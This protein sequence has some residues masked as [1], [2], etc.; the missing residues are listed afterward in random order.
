MQNELITNGFGG[1]LAPLLLD[2]LG[3]GSGGVDL[4]HLLA[5]DAGLNV[6]SP[7][8]DFPY[9]DYVRK[10]ILAVA[11]SS[12]DHME[13]GQTIL[14]LGRLTEV[15]NV[16]N[17]LDV[18]VYKEETIVRSS[19]TAIDK[20]LYYVYPYVPLALRELLVAKVPQPYVDLIYRYVAADSPVARVSGL[21]T[22]VV[23][24]AVFQLHPGA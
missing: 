9:T 2:G 7:W 10:A 1:A 4:E 17:G 19:L 21:A 6:L 14:Q 20:G 15:Y 16:V 22:M 24:A 3:S 11:T 23:M 18:D 13:Q 5:G 12:P 8:T